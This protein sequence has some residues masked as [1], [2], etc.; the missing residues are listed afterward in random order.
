MSEL[1]GFLPGPDGL[2]EFPRLPRFFTDPDH[3]AYLIYSGGTL[4]GFCLTRPFDDEST[5]I[6]AF[7]VVRALRRQGVGRAAAVDLLRSRRGR[8][9]I[10]FLEEY[11][12][13][14][15]FWREVAPEVVGESWTKEC[16][17]GGDGGPTFTF[18]HVDVEE[19]GHVR[20]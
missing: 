9:A 19:D 1:V 12:S 13:A 4:A 7:F 14:A 16:Q 3:D 15:R 5:F 11:D 8:W 10:A 17:T 2:F 20:R 18:I 6:H